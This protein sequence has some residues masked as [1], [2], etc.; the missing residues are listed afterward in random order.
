MKF[1]RMAF[2]EVGT[3]DGAPAP[4]GGLKAYLRRHKFNFV[5]YGNTGDWLVEPVS[6]SVVFDDDTATPVGE[7][8]EQILYDGIEILNQMPETGFDDPRGA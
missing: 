8:V 2:Y 5:R 1:I 7:G 3:P 4:S 6:E